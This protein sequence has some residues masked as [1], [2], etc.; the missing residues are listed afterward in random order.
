MA[1][2]ATQVAKD[3]EHLR[4]LSIFHYVVAGI[5]ALM[6][7]IP[8]V[9]LI[10]GIVM[11]VAGS[12]SKRGAPPV[13]VGVRFIAIGA[14]IVL[15]GWAMAV[16]IFLAGRFLARRRHYMFCFV[17]AVLSCLS[18][19]F[20]TILELRRLA[21]WAVSRRL[22]AESPTPGRRRPAPSPAPRAGGSPAGDAPAPARCHSRP[23][24]RPPST[25]PAVRPLP[26]RVEARR[27]RTGAAAPTV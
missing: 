21:R 26:H 27:D 2:D 15:L 13:L 24:G 17:I 6:A 14:F 10:V 4:L 18:M 25:L 7:C 9:H 23:A 11:V 1:A 12:Q 16:C 5:N 22:P 19:P 20:G 8:F 3:A